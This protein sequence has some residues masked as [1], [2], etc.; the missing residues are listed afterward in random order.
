MSAAALTACAPVRLRARDWLALQALALWPHGAYL[1]E[2]ALDGSDDPLGLLA[3]AAAVG[4][5][6]WQA[7]RL[8]LVP[9]LRWLALAI[10]L[11]LAANAAWVLAVPALAAGVLATLALGA[12]LA[13]WWP[14]AT[15]APR[16]LAPVVGL[17]LLALPLVAS[18]QFYVGYPLRVVTAEAS[19]WALQAAGIDALRSGASMQ[20]SGRLVIVDAPC[21][22]V[23]M[24]WWGYFTACVS[25]A[26]SPLREAGFLR[27]LPAVGAIVLLANVV[28]NSLLVALEARPE[29]LSSTAHQAIGLAALTLACLGVHT[30]MARRAGE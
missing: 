22:G 4:V 14:A 28:R 18:L 5:V 10:A 21:S 13:A 12:S 6:A 17:L 16:P 25:A 23:Q 19:S 8:R 24:A 20:V 3:L 11:T 29:G 1:V 27:R 30:W 7:D 2:R 15:L 26:V 9:R